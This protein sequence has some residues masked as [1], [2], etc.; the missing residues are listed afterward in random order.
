V[1]YYI[2][3]KVRNNGSKERR[4]EGGRKAGRQAGRQADRQNKVLLSKFHHFPVAHQIMKTSVI[5]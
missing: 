1:F 2:K 4:E 3:K 5:D